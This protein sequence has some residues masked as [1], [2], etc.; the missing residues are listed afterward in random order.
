MLNTPPTPCVPRVPPGNPAGGAVVASGVPSAS[1]GL[2][3]LSAHSRGRSG[4]LP[5][6]V[7]FTAQ[8][9]APLP[10]LCREL[11]PGAHGAAPDWLLLVPAGQTAGRDGRSFHLNDPAPVLAAFAA[12]QTDVPV[13]WEHS[14]HKQAPQGLPAPAAG[15]VVELQA[16]EGAVWGRV[17]WTADGAAAITS[18]AY[19]YYSPAYYLDESGAV[20]GIP[21]VGLTGKPNLRLPAM[22]QTDPA[23]A[24][25]EVEIE[26]TVGPADPETAP[27]PVPAP[28]A[29]ALGLSA[30]CTAEAAVAAVAALKEANTVALNRAAVP[31][32]NLYVPRPDL[33]AALNRAEAAETS[34]RLA[35]TA[36]RDKEIEA[37]LQEGLAAARISPPTVAYHRAQAQTP[38]GIARLRE[39][40]GAAAAVLTADTRTGQPPAGPL[41]LNA[42]ERAIA[43]A[44]GNTPE[45]LAKYGAAT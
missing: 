37:L 31:D 14:T 9:P 11:P 26:I 36:E 4:N 16:R 43:A 21:S 2:S 17:E 5:A 44:F 45:T 15:W 7:L 6:A 41:V 25:T 34:L 33:E 13:D 30:D 12:G 18:R 19:R 8:E 39:Y 22:N 20:L 10:L 27:M 29:A 35:Q 24:P 42:D 40:L 1:A 28:L 3:S 38:G 23:P 32:L